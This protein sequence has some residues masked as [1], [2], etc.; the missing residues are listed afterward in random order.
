M[1]KRYDNHR[2]QG[3]IVLQPDGKLEP[4]KKF[5]AELPVSAVSGAGWQ[6]QPAVR[7][8]ATRWHRLGA[9]AFGIPP[10]H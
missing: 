5:I 4:N 1:T 2:A 6:T 9:G 7:P 3:T 8:R 10:Q